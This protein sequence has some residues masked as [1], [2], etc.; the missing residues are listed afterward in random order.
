M[1]K[2]LAFPLA[3]ALLLPLCACGAGEAGETAAPAV[4]CLTPASSLAPVTLEH[5]PP[6]PGTR[7]VETCSDARR[8]PHRRPQAPGT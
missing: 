2:L 8:R 1:K 6:P 5:G 7:T 3:L 4:G